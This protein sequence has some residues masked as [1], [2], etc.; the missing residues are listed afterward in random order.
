MRMEP[1]QF[2][3]RK[4]R[5]NQTKEFQGLLLQLIVIVFYGKVNSVSIL[6]RNVVID[7]RISVLVFVFRRNMVKKWNVDKYS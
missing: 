7:I 3:V 2:N 1:L 5:R 6:L 4:W